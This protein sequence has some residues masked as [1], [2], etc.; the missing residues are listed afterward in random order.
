MYMSLQGQTSH[1]SG[2]SRMFSKSSPNS[3]PSFTCALICEDTKATSALVCSHLDISP[4]CPSFLT[5]WGC[6][7]PLVFIFQGWDRHGKCFNARLF[8]SAAPSPWT[9]AEKHIK[10]SY[11]QEELQP[12][13]THHWFASWSHPVLHHCCMNLVDEVCMEQKQQSV[14]L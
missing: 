5:V 7:P 3:L 4:S 8:P 10:P 14:K 12:Q 9:C 1:W 13:A 2:T 6:H 11:Y